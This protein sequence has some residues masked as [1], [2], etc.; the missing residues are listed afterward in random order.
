MIEW[1]FESYTYRKSKSVA[2][3]RKFSNCNAFSRFFACTN[4]YKPAAK[5]TIL[6]RKSVVRK[7]GASNTRLFSQF[8]VQQ[9]CHLLSPAIPDVGVDVLSHS[10]SAVA[11]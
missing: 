4:L 10:Y 1:A 2:I 7:A 11:Q 9:A 5:Y 8:L 3:T 6:C